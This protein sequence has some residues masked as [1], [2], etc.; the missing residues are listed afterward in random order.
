MSKHFSHHK[1]RK[2]LFYLII[3]L[4]HD[5]HDHFH[6]LVDILLRSDLLLRIC[7]N[8]YHHYDFHGHF[9]HHDRGLHHFCYR[10]YPNL[11]MN[12][13]LVRSNHYCWIYYLWPNLTHHFDLLPMSLFFASFWA[14]K[15]TI[16]SFIQPKSSNFTSEDPVLLQRC[17]II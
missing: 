12:Y 13:Y 15:N 4:F 7:D 9:D 3:T 10:Y 2:N 1:I 5:L 16:I 14:A 17:T 11:K 6:R 8:F